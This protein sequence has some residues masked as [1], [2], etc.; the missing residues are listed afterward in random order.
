MPYVPAGDAAAKAIAENPELSDRAIAEMTGIGHAT[1][2]RRRAATVSPETVEPRIGRDGKRR[3]MP[4]KREPS[5]ILRDKYADDWSG[6][7]APKFARA[8]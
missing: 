1:V 8:R 4:A 3:K 2:S 5:E 7:N 6:C